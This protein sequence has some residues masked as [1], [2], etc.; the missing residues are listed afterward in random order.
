M[1]VRYRE[2]PHCPDI[3]LTNGGEVV[4]LTHRPLSTSQKI[5]FSVLLVIIYFSGLV[6]LRNLCGWKN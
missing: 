6:N 4:N 3:R 2:P 1:V 5:F